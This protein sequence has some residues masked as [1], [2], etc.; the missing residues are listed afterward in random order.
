MNRQSN[1]LAGLPRP[2]LAALLFAVVAVALGFGAILPILPLMVEQLLASPD[3]SGV[4][5]HTALLTGAFAVA[6]LATALPWGRLSD[7][8]GR[9]PILTI[10]LVGFSLT[11]AATGL[12]RDLPSL[13]AARFL[14]GGFA[15]AVLPTALALV[16]DIEVDENKRAR[17]FGRVNVAFGLGL[18]AG[19]MLGGLASNGD[20]TAFGGGLPFTLVAGIAVAGAFAVW[21]VAPR[22]APQ[23][24]QKAGLRSSVSSARPGEAGLLVLAALAA[25]GLGAFEVG[26][27]LR[28]RELAIM[29]ESLGLMFA[30]CMVVMLVVQAIAFSTLVKPATTRRLLAPMFAVMGLGLA[31]LPVAA[32]PNSLL[33][34]TGMVAAAGGLLTPVLA[35]WV[36]WISGRGQGAE[37]G[38]QT[39]AVALGQTLGA[40]G[41]GLL[42]E[43]S[44]IAGT[45]FLLPAAMAIATG[46]AL[47]LP[48]Q[49]GARGSR[50]R[51]R[52]TATEPARHTP[53]S[54]GCRC[55]S[56]DR[57]IAVEREAGHG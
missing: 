48:A 56:A 30:T 15:A 33:A 28:S 12:A 40:V 9:R 38:L 54:S 16:A 51:D 17:T 26:L 44:G 36:S 43:F 25:G 41:A 20:V 46:M 55:P 31:L 22:D 24:R 35:Y 3:P 32:G 2:T 19:P 42:F 34:V 29:P 52:S 39:A 23:Q 5:W 50:L 7:R 45:P 6:P 13:Y 4:A 18:L 49:Q 14:S 10:G 53:R 1:D 37:L 57:T 8:Y 11:F 27:T 21:S 47:A